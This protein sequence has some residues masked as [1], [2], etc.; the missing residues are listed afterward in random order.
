MGLSFSNCCQNEDYPPTYSE[1]LHGRI[2]QINNELKRGIITRE[3]Y[4]EKLIQMWIESKYVL[5][6][7]Y[8]QPRNQ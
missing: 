4:R 3:E 2:E 1:Y 8:E 6:T 7:L 5:E